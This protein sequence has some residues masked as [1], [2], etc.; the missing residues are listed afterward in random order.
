[1][2]PLDEYISAYRE[3]LAIRK[4]D[5]VYL[6]SGNMGEKQGLEIVLEVAKRLKRFK[7]IHFILCGEGVAK[8]RL[9]LQAEQQRLKQVHFL[10]LQPI[11]RLNDLLNTAD[12][13]LLIQKNNASDLV[14]PSKL[15]GILASGRCIIATANENT[16]VAQAMSE[17]NAGVVVQAEQMEQLAD[18]IY[19]LS[20]DKELRRIYGK[21]ARTYAENRLGLDSIMHN[22]HRDISDL[23]SGKEN[24]N[25]GGINAQG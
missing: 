3:Q 8:E 20:L 1:M 23:A 21:N 19:S 25:E 22:F 15:T 9:L 2:Y 24:V 5:I 18:A 4:D 12:V 6:Y 13:H 11:E 10:P 7:H 17:A 14:M 16:S